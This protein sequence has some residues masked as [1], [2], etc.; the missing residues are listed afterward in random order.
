MISFIGSEVECQAVGPLGSNCTLRNRPRGG[1]F[2]LVFGLHDISV[3]E[4]RQQLA[5]LLASPDFVASDRNRKFLIFVVE[6][7]LA[8]RSDRIKGYTVATQA[9]GR[10]EGFDA[11]L[12]PV[13]RIEALRL[14]R[15]LERY[16]LLSGADDPVRISIQKGSYVPHFT[17]IEAHTVPQSPDD[18]ASSM[19]R[20]EGKP[21]IHVQRFD[22]DTDSAGDL[23]RGFTRLLAA[24]L[25][26]FAGIAIF[27]CGETSG[28]E[29]AE[30]CDFLLTGTVTEGD[31]GFRVDVLLIEEPSGRHFW[32]DR[33]EAK[34]APGSGTAVRDEFAAR[35]AGRVAQPYGMVF[36]SRLDALAKR[37]SGPASAYDC[38]VQFYRYWRNSDPNVCEEVRADLEQALVLEPNHAEAVACLSLVYMDMHRFGYNRTGV[39]HALARALALGRSAVALAPH[40]SR[41]HHAFGLALWFSGD[42]DGGVEALETGLSLNPYD[43]EIMAD[44]G[45]RQAIRGNC[46][47]GRSLIEKAYAHNPALPDVFRIGISLE[48]FAHDRF[49]EALLQARRI[50]VP[51]VVYG[52][53]L[54]AASATRLGR[55]DDAARAVADIIA[56]DPMYA[57]RAEKDLADRGLHAALLRKLLDALEDAGLHAEP[58]PMSGS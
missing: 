22:G 21:S 35:I 47:Q 49:E 16:Y 43:S 8:G 55:L 26:R 12:D 27:E 13:V 4:I 56:L 24:A 18:R 33:L 6:E 31:D 38:V 25:T 3:D 7:T 52:P 42:H 36:A 34:V 14:R 50:A 5:V 30:T 2:T 44:L 53:L 54:I 15:A 45:L 37:G 19:L 17:R 20:T 23:A 32:A 51:S 48:A 57:A 41:S 9:F 10:G 1:D 11:Q 46:S 29:G 40:A 58:Q 28:T 39:P